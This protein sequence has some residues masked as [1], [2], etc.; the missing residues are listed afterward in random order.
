MGFCPSGARGGKHN[1]MYEHCYQA[2]MI[3]ALNHSMVCMT[4]RSSTVLPGLTPPPSSSP[5]KDMASPNHK[6]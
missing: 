6:V 5:E 3:I 1:R 2:Q 4:N